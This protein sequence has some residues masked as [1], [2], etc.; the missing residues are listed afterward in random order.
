M[1]PDQWIGL[2]VIALAAVIIAPAA[3]HA[4]AR[5]FVWAVVRIDGDPLA[6]TWATVPRDTFYD[7][8]RAEWAA[9][10]RALPF[11][12]ALAEEEMGRP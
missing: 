4:L 10:G 3:W 5:A 11:D 1:N 9:D 6:H 7:T 8:L 2:G 12:W